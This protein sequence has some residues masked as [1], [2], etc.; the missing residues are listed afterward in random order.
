MALSAEHW[1]VRIGR[2][3]RLRDLH[4]LLTAA[5]CGS[6]SKAARRLSVSQPA[7]SKAITDLEHALKVRLLDRGPQGITLTLYGSAL[8]RRSLAAFDELHQAVSEIEFI[9]NPTEGEVRIGCNDPLSG[10]LLPAVIDQMSTQ[11]ARVTVHV[12]PIGRPIGTEISEL[13]DRKVDLVIVRGVTPSDERV[14]AE[15]LFEEPLVVVVGARSKWAR[16]RAVKLADLA[17][18]K[19]IFEPAQET[20]TLLVEDAFRRHGVTVP[21][22]CVT[23]SSFHMREALLTDGDYVTVVPASSVAALNASQPRVKALPIDLGV[24]L[25]PVSILTLKNRT[26][27][28]VAEIALECIRRVAAPLR[29]IRRAHTGRAD[30]ESITQR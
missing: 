27:N 16:R 9:A 10:T 30:R 4:V 14:E 23:S 2:R 29:G 15:R 7:V 17:D 6:M 13:T 20:P 19:W 3:I 18:A 5:Q 1:Q 25:R 11:Y 8:V 22:A 26:L 12:T 24:E 21:R 28:P